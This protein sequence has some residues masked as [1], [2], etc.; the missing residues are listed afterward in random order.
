VGDAFAR[1]DREPQT[2]LQ[3]EEGHG[4]VLKLRAYN[5]LRI[6][7]KPVPIEPERLLQVI[8]ADGDNGDSWLH[9]DSIHLLRK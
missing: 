2:G 5:A 4:P 9:V 3:V 7:P 8:D 6:E 1:P